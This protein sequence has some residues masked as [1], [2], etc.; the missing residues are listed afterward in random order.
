MLLTT[1]LFSLFLGT[2]HLER[3]VLTVQQGYIESN[4]NAKAVGKAKEKGAWQVREKYWGKVPKELPAQAEQAEK[5]LNDLLLE[6]RYDLFLSTYRYNGKGKAAVR[7][8]V[9]LRQR[10]IQS[11][12]LG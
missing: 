3:P 1:I 5:I 2:P 7:Y 11:A 12:L 9:N 6:S 10:S 8:A 4:M